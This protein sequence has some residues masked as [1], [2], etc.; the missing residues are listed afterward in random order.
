MY[1][2]LWF[3]REMK[4]MNQNEDNFLTE[5]RELSDRILHSMNSFCDN[6]HN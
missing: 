5:L 2:K 4:E 3:K 1:I 6:I